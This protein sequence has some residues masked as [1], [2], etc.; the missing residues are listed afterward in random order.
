MTLRTWFALSL[1]AVPAAGQR[2]LVVSEFQRLRPDG[3][4]ALSDRTQPAQEFISPAI[5]R[6][7]VLTVRL[8]VEVPQGMKYSL[9][10]GQN[11]DGTAQYRLYQERYVQVGQEWLPDEIAPVG[12][13]QGATLS[14]GQ[15]V[16]SYLLDI[17]I[18]ATAK[19][20][21]F[22][23]EIQLNV[24]E[25]WVIYPMEIRIRD[26]IVRAEPEIVANTIRPDQRVDAA[27]L[28]PLMGFACGTTWKKG[29]GQLRRGGDLITRNAMT[30]LLVAQ[31]RMKLETREA[32][33]STIL[34]AGGYQSREAFCARP[35]PVPAS[36][37]WWL[38]VRKYLYQ[39]LPVN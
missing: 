22:R 2:L 15:S 25:R 14:A 38:R 8:G 17:R 19:P 28:I 24:G 30:D 29:D 39:G 32:V 35:S 33:V 4:V 18:P 12:L 23:L 37:E 7:G 3:E 31:Q 6:G 1:L 10:I 21:R 27:L 9:F 5:P 16:Q 26:L 34:R 20:Q 36:A 13:P 11:P